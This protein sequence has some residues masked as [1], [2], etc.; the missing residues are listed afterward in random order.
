METKTFKG[1]TR[2]EHELQMDE[3]RYLH[4]KWRE[5]AKENKIGFFPVFEGFLPYLQKLSPHAVR[6]YLYL[7]AFVNNVTGECTV[8]LETMASFF[9]CEK[10][11]VQKWLKELTDHKLL[12]RVQPEFQKPTVTF[13]LPYH[14]SFLPQEKQ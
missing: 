8:S 1:K 10:R 3:Y 5:W 2:T 14:K 4:S 6:L 7:G 9:E 12:A 13:V 11:T